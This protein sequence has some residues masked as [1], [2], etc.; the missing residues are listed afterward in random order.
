MTPQQIQKMVDSGFRVE[1]MLTGGGIGAVHTLLTTPGASRLVEGATIPYSPDAL[2]RLLGAMP[3]QAVSPHTAVAMASAGW[4]ERSG[5]KGVPDRA[6]QVSCTAALQTDRPRRGE[7]RAF[8]CIRTAAR[9]NLYAL[10]LSP[11]SR[12]GQEAVLSRWIL[13]LT[14][15]A[16][17]TEPLLVYP[18]SFNPL[19]CGHTR[20]LTV[21]EKMT[22]HAGFFELSCCTVDK[23][24]SGMDECIRRAAAILDVPVALTSAPRFVEKAALFPGAVFVLGYDTAARLVRDAHPGEWDLF[25]KA[26]VRFL[27]AGRRV[28]DAFLS[29]DDLP[30]PRQADSL[31]DAI[32]EPLFREDI[33][34]TELRIR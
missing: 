5:E 27:T 17:S 25:R 4:K 16:C 12:A 7:D 1:F 6:V 19:H 15:Q 24:M 30:L 23:P 20:L 34:S 31:F 9:E 28:G 29:L 8:I 13:H 18:G 32:P 11:A 26:G 2:A 14:A 33:S 3:A 10:F 22:G 21:A